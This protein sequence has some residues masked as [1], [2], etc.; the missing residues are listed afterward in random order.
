MNNSNGSVCVCDFDMT[1]KISPVFVIYPQL[2]V[3]NPYL[4]SRMNETNSS[5][6]TKESR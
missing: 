1:F 4:L 2:L 3:L 5:S 6:K